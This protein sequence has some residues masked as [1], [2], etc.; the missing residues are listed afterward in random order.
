M[1]MFA[2]YIFVTVSTCGIVLRRTKMQ[3]YTEQVQ[4][5]VPYFK[6]LVFT[7]GH[8]FISGDITVIPLEILFAVSANNDQLGNAV[9]TKPY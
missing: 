5:M 6:P 7:V 3:G 4:M 1:S 2:N 8:D 9:K